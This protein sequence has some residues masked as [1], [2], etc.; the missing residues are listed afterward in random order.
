VSHRISFAATHT[1]MPPFIVAPI[2]RVHPAALTLGCMRCP[3]Q[4]GS[5][6]R[7]VGLEMGL[8]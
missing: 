3:D 4:L 1:A 8:R 2:V 6:R 5:V 7:G